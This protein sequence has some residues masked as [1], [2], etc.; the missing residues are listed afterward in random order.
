MTAVAGTTPRLAVLAS[1][2]G[3]NLQAILDAI[4]DGRLDARVAGVFGDRPKAVALRRARDVGHRPAGCG[5]G[6]RR[7]REYDAPRGSPRLAARVEPDFSLRWLH[8][9]AWRKRSNLEGR[10]INIILAAARL[11][12]TGHARRA[13]EAGVAAWAAC[14]TSADLVRP[15]I[16]R[17]GS[18]PAG[19]RR[20]T[21]A[22]RVLAWE[23][24]LMLATRKCSAQVAHSR[25]TTV[26]LTDRR[27]GN[28]SDGIQQPAGM[29]QSLID[30]HPCCDGFRAGPGD[31]LAARRSWPA[32]PRPHASPTEDAALTAM[33]APQWTRRHPELQ[34]SSH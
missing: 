27:S 11:Q 29:S 23:H 6:L 4:A 33:P 20:D 31:A 19:R 2:R 18:G 7:A 24:P 28:A 5:P 1:G 3:S 9:P 22:S 13:L 12:G 21:L 25:D 16:G 14:I 8:E 17:R 30:T 26:E 34:P 32:T 15:V 10:I